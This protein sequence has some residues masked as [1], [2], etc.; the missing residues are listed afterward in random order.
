M[1]I[2]SRHGIFNRTNNTIYYC[3][4]AVW[5]AL[6]CAGGIMCK[7]S[8]DFLSLNPSFFG[9]LSSKDRYLFAVNTGLGMS[10]L[11]NYKTPAPWK[12]VEFSLLKPYLSVEYSSGTVWK[13]FEILFDRYELCESIDINHRKLCHSM[14]I[15][16]ICL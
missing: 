16:C 14:N 5:V 8:I 1:Y 12:P 13:K 7:R 11:R 10:S 6:L 2:F 4:Y 15:S 3:R 9:N